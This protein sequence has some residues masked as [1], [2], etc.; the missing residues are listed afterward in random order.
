MVVL[1][2]QAGRLR[3]NVP[4]L[5]KD[6]GIT[7]LCSSWPKAGQDGWA[8]CDV[9]DAQPVCKN[10]MRIHLKKSNAVLLTKQQEADLGKLALID[11]A[12]ADRKRQEWLARLQGE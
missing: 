4:H 8:I 1:E 10:C 11:P 9:P 3:N 2:K 6:D 7:A 5:L 12:L